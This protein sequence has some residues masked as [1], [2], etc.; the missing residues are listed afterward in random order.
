MR[1]SEFAARATEAA[2][3]LIEDHQVKMDELKARYY[4]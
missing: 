1:E 2:T 3:F 4:G